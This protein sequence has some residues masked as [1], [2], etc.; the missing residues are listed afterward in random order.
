[1]YDR[2]V[3]LRNSA[4]SPVIGTVLTLVILVSAIGV[5][6]SWGIPY[7]ERLKV[8]SEQKSVYSQFDLWDESLR[9]LV[10]EGVNATRINNF[11]L[12]QGNLLLDT[13][14]RRFV[15]YY[16]MKPG[17]DCI[18]YDFNEYNFTIKA[19][20]SL[21]DTIDEVIINWLENGG[22]EIHSNLSIKNDTDNVTISVSSPLEKTVKMS[23]YNSSDVVAKAWVFNLGK[24][25]WEASSSSGVYGLR[26]ENEGIMVSIPG[27]TTLQEG[28]IFY[29]K[30]NALFMTTSLIRGRMFSGNGPALYKVVT[31]LGE[32]EVLENSA[33]VY[34]LT[35]SI[36][37]A[38]ADLWIRYFEDKGFS[39]VLPFDDNARRYNQTEIELTFLK[40]MFYTRLHM[41]KGG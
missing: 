24:L 19:N 35:L 28:F 2:R 12:N 41:A 18:L 8:E 7:I 27:Q 33:I 31:T 16:F 36:D 14:G 29:N 11:A 3:K 10:I 4:V 21:P 9:D 23:F 6:L 32:S 30:S 26:A 13:F 20:V 25:Q 39:K 34:N 40:V 1:M 37:G 17:Y 38:N 5:V 22:Q 15:I